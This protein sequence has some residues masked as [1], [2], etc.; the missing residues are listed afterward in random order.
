YILIIS[1]AGLSQ[2]G[3]KVRS[4][5]ALLVFTAGFLGLHEVI[6]IMISVFA[7]PLGIWQEVSELMQLMM[8]LLAIQKL[9]QLY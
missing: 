5:W 3:G 7:L 2:A 4:A 9:R 8:L 1:I 6:S